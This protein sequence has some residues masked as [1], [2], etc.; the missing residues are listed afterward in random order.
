MDYPMWHA[1]ETF[2]DRSVAMR[3]KEVLSVSG[4]KSSVKKYR[5]TNGF[6]IWHLFTQ[7]RVDEARQILM[8]WRLI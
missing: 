8:A 1:V 5:S 7:G 6:D 4:Y 3:A 2:N